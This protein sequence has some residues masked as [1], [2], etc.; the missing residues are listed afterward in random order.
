MPLTRL[1]LTVSDD[2]CLALPLSPP[3]GRAGRSIFIPF[4]TTHPV[5]RGRSAVARL[6]LCLLG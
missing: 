6:L 3:G 5:S 2:D 1:E 4:V